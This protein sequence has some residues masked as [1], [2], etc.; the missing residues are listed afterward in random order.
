[1]KV[2]VIIGHAPDEKGAYS[3]VLEKTEFDFW[4]TKSMYLFAAIRQVA[5]CQIFLREEDQTRQ[6]IIA[7]VNAYAPTLAIELHFNDFEQDTVSGYETLI[8]ADQHKHTPLWSQLV[9]S[10]M[11]AALKD[12]TLAR[13]NYPSARDRGIKIL[14]KGNRGYSNLAGL[15]CPACLIE[16]FFARNKIDAK[17]FSSRVVPFAEGLAK[18]VK[19]FKMLT[20]G[21]V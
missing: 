20:G 3:P 12:Y 2:A 7:A 13:I 10:A 17:R 1:M 21:N 14:V 5:E 19:E 6:H 16:P 15:K 18:A 4:H 11:G 8:A 9:H